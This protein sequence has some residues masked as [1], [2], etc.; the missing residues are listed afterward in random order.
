M[1]IV[2][3]PRRRESQVSEILKNNDQTLFVSCKTYVTFIL[4]YTYSQIKIKD[5][6]K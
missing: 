5:L 2:S 6:S 4:I 1:R 3:L